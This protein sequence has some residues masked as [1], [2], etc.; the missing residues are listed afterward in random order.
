MGFM[1]PTF[2]RKEMVPAER[3]GFS[4]S[5]QKPKL[6]LEYLQNA[7]VSE[8]F[9][10]VSHWEPYSATDFHIA[11]TKDYVDHF[12]GG[13]EPE[14]SSNGL[15]WNPEFAKSVRFTN[16]SLYNAICYAIENQT[17]SFSPT[18]GFHHATPE[19]GRGFC[20]FSGQVIASL[21]I[22]REKKK[23]GAYIDLDGHF[24]NSIEDSRTFCPDL[25]E[26]IPINLN[27][28]GSHSHYLKDAKTKFEEVLSLAKEGKI[29]YFV[30]CSGADSLE[31]DDLGSHLSLEE[32]L[33]LK[34]W[35]YDKISTLDSSKKKFPSTIS[36]F[37]GY[38]QD[39]Y[40]SV[41]DAH[42]Q[43]LLLCLRKRFGLE[44]KVPSVYRRR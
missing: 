32:W 25:N 35:M 23:K 36:L 26:A 16:A 18:S 6:L 34:E 44:Q 13:V 3:V 8:Y 11:H 2:Y 28:N 39:H 38:R 22:W 33:H 4:Q 40:E 20:S 24:G 5:P 19:S 15:Q 21:K 10:I 42:T 12:F 37:G 14:A 41:L 29:D 31:D 27:P 17:V 1:I 43:D 30:F 7:G 9:P